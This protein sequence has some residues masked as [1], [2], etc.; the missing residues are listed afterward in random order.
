[1]AETAEQMAAAFEAEANVAPVVN[2]SGV[3][4]P[5]VAIGLENDSTKSSKFYTEDDLAR[6]RSCLLYTSP[7]PRD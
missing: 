3:D 6:V 7:S 2:V 5:T 1:M 4:A